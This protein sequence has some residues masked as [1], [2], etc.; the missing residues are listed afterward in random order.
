MILHLDEQNLV[1]AADFLGAQDSSLALVINRYGYPPLWAREQ[2][3]ASLVHIILEQQVSLE[4]AR[5]AFNRLNTRLGIVS[6]ANFLTLTDDEL[7]FIGFSRQKKMYVRG[8]AEAI[9]TGNFSVENLSLLDDHEVKNDLKKLKGIGDWTADVYLLFSL[10]RPD[11]LPKGDIAL[12]EA[13]RSLKN[14]DKRPDYD[15]FIA[16][17]DHWRPW[18]SVGC[19]L[20]WHFYL[21]ERGRS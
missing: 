13:I 5:A 12:Y 11:V 8:V 20:L 16:L 15:Q 18:R 4:S 9:L 17:T 21:C 6:P 3:F 14:L 2:S 1:T 7:L 19:R 10:R